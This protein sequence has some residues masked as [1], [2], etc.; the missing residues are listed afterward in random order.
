MFSCHM[1]G[2]GVSANDRSWPIVD[3]P[4]R[5]L[6]TLNRRS[7]NANKSQAYTFQFASLPWGKA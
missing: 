1:E 4:D 3:P 2:V 6:A 5:V 7:D